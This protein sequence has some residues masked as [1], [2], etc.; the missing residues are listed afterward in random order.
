MFKTAKNLSDQIADHLTEN[1]ICFKISPGDRLLEQKVA[2]ELGV[3]RSPVREAFRILEKSGLVELVPRCG[4]KVAGFTE[5]RIEAYCDMFILLFGHVV[6]R[7]IESCDAAHRD[8]LIIILEQLENCAE[9]K[10]N[11]GFYKALLDF[12][13]EG[14]SSTKNPVLRQVVMSIMPNLQRLQYIAIMLRGDALGQNLIYFQTIID[15][16]EERDPEKGA[17]AIEAYIR[18]EKE[19]TMTLVK[20]TPLS[21][22][23]DGVEA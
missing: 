6:R 7:C 17:R 1:I 18:N 4:V 15:A 3:S 23:L 5:E 11:R 22:F 21:R 8:R 19:Y 9:R 12:I 10:D 16:L 14:I 2:E 20:N 13:A